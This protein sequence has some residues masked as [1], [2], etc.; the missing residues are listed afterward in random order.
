MSLVAIEHY[1][2]VVLIRPLSLEVANWLEEHTHG[3]WWGG[4][5]VVEPRY[6]EDL[7]AS[8][9]ELNPPC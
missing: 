4:A 5:L 3:T 6:V 7:L 8:L 9:V 2:S 1:G